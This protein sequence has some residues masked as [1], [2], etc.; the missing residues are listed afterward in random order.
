MVQQRRDHNQ[1]DPQTLR[2]PRQS[3]HGGKLHPPRPLRVPTPIVRHRRR[4]EPCRHQSRHRPAPARRLAQREL[5]ARR[6]RGRQLP[7]SPTAIHH[8]PKQRKHRKPRRQPD[9]EWRC[10]RRRAATGERVGQPRAAE[11]GY[12]RCLDVFLLWG[13]Y[14]YSPVSL[15]LRRSSLPIF[16][17]FSHTQNNNYIPPPSSRQKICFFSLLFGFNHGGSF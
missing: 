5:G 8:T 1:G 2:R 7:P 14:H 17:L 3:A 16:F 15:P 11:P 10:R 13:T 9:A 4:R 6:R 12:G